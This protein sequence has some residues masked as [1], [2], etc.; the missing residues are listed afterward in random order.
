MLGL[1]ELLVVFGDVHAVELWV[2]VADVVEQ[3]RRLVE[4]SRG[5]CELPFVGFRQ[6]VGTRELDVLDE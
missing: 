3:D 5:G 4:V 6:A 1:G 2:V